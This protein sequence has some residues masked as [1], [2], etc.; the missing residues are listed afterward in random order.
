[1]ETEKKKFYGLTKT[2]YV[3]IIT[4]KERSKGRKG[5]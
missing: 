4:G 1:M 2:K 3:T 5:R